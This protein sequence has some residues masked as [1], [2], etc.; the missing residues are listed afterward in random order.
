VIGIT[1]NALS[2]L[3]LRKAFNQKV[4]AL[5]DRAAHLRL[6]RGEAL[7]DVKCADEEPMKTCADRFADD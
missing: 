7:L 4:W 2:I 6:K 3:S 1:P 5:P